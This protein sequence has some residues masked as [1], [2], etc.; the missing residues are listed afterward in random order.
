M[1]DI[2]LTTLNAKYIHSSFGLRYLK[3]NLG[4][5]DSQCT[6][7]EYTIQ[8]RPLDIVQELLAANPKIIGMESTFGMPHRA[9][10]WCACSKKCAQTS[11][12]CLGAQRSPTSISS[13][14]SVNGRPC[15][16]REGEVAFESF[17]Q[18][19]CPVKVSPSR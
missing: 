14:P 1:S 11:P 4:P 6:L 17:A 13:R 3:A 16:F 8:H 2:I 18:P 5:L 15:H 19:C 7:M 10:R 9:C 12:L